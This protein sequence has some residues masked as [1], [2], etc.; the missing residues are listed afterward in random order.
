MDVLL[1]ILV[2]VVL[3][4]FGKKYELNRRATEKVTAK[5]AIPQPSPVVFSKKGNKQPH[6]EKWVRF[7]F[8]LSGD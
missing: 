3:G 8:I 7:Y 5:K 2:A 6:G 1:W 4:Y